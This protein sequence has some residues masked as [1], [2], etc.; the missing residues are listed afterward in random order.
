MK[1]VIAESRPNLIVDAVREW[2]QCGEGELAAP[3]RP[4]IGS[5]STYQAGSPYAIG[6]DGVS[7]SVPES[8]RDERMAVLCVWGAP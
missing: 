4:L 7:D 6:R 2:A 5:L 3:T 1:L 8:V